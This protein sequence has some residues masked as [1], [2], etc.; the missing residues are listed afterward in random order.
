[1]IR[2]KKCKTDLTQ[3]SVHTYDDIDMGDKIVIVC[4]HSIIV[5]NGIKI[6]NRLDIPN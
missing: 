6:F 4:H 1:M 3:E 5:L 2:H